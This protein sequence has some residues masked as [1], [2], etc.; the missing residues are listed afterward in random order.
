MRHHPSC[1]S[2][3]MTVSVCIYFQ[4]TVTLRDF[5]D[6]IHFFYDDDND[7]YNNSGA[8]PP[9]SSRN[10]FSDVSLGRCVSLR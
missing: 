2:V 10:V 1:S 3:M 5:F 4:C 8:L 7:D 9:S 6:S